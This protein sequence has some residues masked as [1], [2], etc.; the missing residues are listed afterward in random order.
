MADQ[1]E[2]WINL[3]DRTAELR[4]TVSDVCSEIAGTINSPEEIYQD[5]G[6]GSLSNPVLMTALLEMKRNQELKNVSEILQTRP[7]IGRRETGSATVFEDPEEESETWMRRRQSVVTKDISWF[8]NNGESKEIMLQARE[9]RERVLLDLYLEHVKMTGE[10]YFP[11]L[12]RLLKAE[13]DFSSG[14]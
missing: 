2:S 4:R 12:H 1:V 10:T 13:W 9:Y 8:I 3:E 7:S 5:L 14:T 6:W 11:E